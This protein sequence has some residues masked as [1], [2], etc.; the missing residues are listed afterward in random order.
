MVDLVEKPENFLG[1]AVW[2]LA[3]NTFLGEDGP[4]LGKR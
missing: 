1:D 2:C 4:S 3:G